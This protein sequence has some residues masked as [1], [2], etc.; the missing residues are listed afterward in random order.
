MYKALLAC[1]L[2]AG[3]FY[4]AV[5]LA[6]AW[7]RPGF[8]LTRHPLSLLST[9]DLGWIQITNFIVSGVLVVAGSVGMRR[10]LRT[11]R[12]ST[13]GPLLVGLFG[14]GLIGAGIFAPDPAAGFPPG[15]PA[16]TTTI[17]T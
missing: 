12:A 11:G 16:T 8:D 9:G 7:T 10:A 6:Q 2:A 5:S 3:P 4:F 13:W 1:G 17:S 15:T 14:V